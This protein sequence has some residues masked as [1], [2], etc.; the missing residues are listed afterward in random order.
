MDER[1]IPK[2]S[3]VFN[4][5][6]FPDEALVCLGELDGNGVTVGVGSTVVDD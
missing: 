3:A 4:T 5:P 1:Y 2:R 6:P